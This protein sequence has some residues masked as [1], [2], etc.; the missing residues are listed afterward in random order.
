MIGVWTYKSRPPGRTGGSRG[1][2]LHA[3]PPN[4]LV[5]GRRWA[6]AEKFERMPLF[7]ERIGF[8]VSEAIDDLA[9]FDFRGLPL[10]SKALTNPRDANVRPGRRLLISV[11]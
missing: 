2:A 9:G 3:Y 11:S 6:I 10:P 8:R 4:V 1:A 5:R 7:L